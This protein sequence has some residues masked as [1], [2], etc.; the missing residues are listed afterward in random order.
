M[1]RWANDLT[2]ISEMFRDVH[3]WSQQQLAELFGLDVRSIQPVEQS[4]DRLW[5]S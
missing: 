1:V 5:S 4:Q 3:Y 2:E